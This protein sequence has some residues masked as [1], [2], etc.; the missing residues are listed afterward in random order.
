MEVLFDKSFL[1]CIQK[2]NDKSLKRKI[3]SFI[4]DLEKVN[5]IQEITSVKK[6]SGSKNAYRKRIG[7]YRIG[8]EVD[9]NSIILIIAAHRRKI[10]RYF[11]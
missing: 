10:Y 1:K 6:L 11:P 8:F 2:I 4:E 7:D 5:D 3:L 9:N